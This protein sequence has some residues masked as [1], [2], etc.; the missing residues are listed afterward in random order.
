MPIAG[1]CYHAI[2]SL[3]SSPTNM[4]T[5]T[6]DTRLHHHRKS[7]YTE[8]AF[9]LAGP[10]CSSTSLVGCAFFNQS[11]QTDDF[12]PITLSQLPQAKAPSAALRACK[13][14]LRNTELVL[15]PWSTLPEV[16]PCAPPFS[17][18][19]SNLCLLNSCLLDWIL[20]I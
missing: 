10:G 6:L 11:L 12:A 13:A 5:R 20:N 7:S 19:I 8:S 1:F 14:A 2:K 17:H 18:S 15:T 3:T 4:P 9:C 16:P